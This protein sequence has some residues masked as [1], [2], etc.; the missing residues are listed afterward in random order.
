MNIWLKYKDEVHGAGQGDS[1]IAVLN[2]PRYIQRV[3]GVNGVEPM[4]ASQ[5]E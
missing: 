2:P 1:V 5:G 3:Q 4:E